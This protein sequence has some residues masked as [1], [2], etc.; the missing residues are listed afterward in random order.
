MLIIWL[1]CNIHKI[2]GSQ[3]KNSHN[4]T[5]GQVFLCTYLNIYAE[6]LIATVENIFSVEQENHPWMKF[7]GYGQCKIKLSVR[8]D[9][10]FS[11]PFPGQEG[12]MDATV[13]CALQINLRKSLKKS[14][15]SYHIKINL[16]GQRLPKPLTWSVKRDTFRKQW[17]YLRPEL[18]FEDVWLFPLCT[19]RVSENYCPYLNTY[20]TYRRLGLI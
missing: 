18:C 15:Y 20:S 3:L 13:F 19:R 1:S 14:L 17:N 12:T 8:T 11:V 9:F 6:V 4:N 10:I 2:S 7:H 16:K 5:I